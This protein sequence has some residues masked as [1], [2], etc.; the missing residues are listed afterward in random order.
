MPNRTTFASRRAIRNGQI[1]ANTTTNWDPV[2]VTA[3]ATYDRNFLTTLSNVSNIASIPVGSLVEGTGVGRE[4]YVT[5]KDDQ[6]G[7]ITLS[8]P[9]VRA[10]ASQSYTFT[11]FQYMLDFSGF[12][13]ISRFQI[14]D[15][16]FQCN[17]LASAV[18][19]APDGDPPG[20]SATAGSPSPASRH[21]LY[22]QRMQ[23]DFDRPQPVYLARRV[24]D[25][26]PEP[27]KRSRSIPMKTT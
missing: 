26:D 3:T 18:M 22:R 5:A 14:D 20:R 10:A 17:G 16:E 27:G 12:Q 4:I 15:V 21:H 11:R 1:S 23:R 9:L 13:S 25:A 2:I 8:K 19:L 24:I 7:T 6:A